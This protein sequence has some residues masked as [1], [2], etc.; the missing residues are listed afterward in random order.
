MNP[1]RRYS[2]LAKRYSFIFKSEEKLKFTL[3]LI[4]DPTG[5]HFRSDGHQF[6]CGFAPEIDEPVEYDDFKV[7]YRLWEEKIWSTLANRIPIFERIKFS[8]TF[9]VIK[10]DFK[11]VWV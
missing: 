5:I 1:P 4:I 9:L 3:P 7:D 11:Q 6:L 2:F 8:S 10:A